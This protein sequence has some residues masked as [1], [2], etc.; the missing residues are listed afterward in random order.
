MKPALVALVLLAALPLLAADVEQFLL[1]V[2]PSLVHCGYDS[3]YETRLV[4][5]NDNALK[6][7]VLCATGDC[8]SVQPLA[9]VEFSGGYAGGTPLPAY[10]YLP[11][12]SAERLRMSLI[13]E[14]SE[15]SRLDERSYTELPIVSARD[16]T[17]GK[18]QFVGVRVDKGF[19]QTVRMYGLDGTKSGQVMMRVYPMD[20]AVL[21]HECLHDIAP[22]TLEK[23]PEGHDL[24]P[25]FGM[26]CDMS[27]HIP[28]NN[29]KVRIELEPVT[30]GLEYWAFIS[31]TNNKTQHFYTV[32]GR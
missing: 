2:S 18:M 14:S 28:A 7:D 12:E 24:R 1:P 19:R 17:R 15:L 27:D 10:V 26:E 5:F 30:E 6:S 31:I 13:V 8:A 16:F 32:L 29:Q 23:T 3:R 4:A 11:K 22:I 20:S 9:T 21:M 25:A